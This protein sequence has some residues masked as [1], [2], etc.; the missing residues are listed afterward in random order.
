MENSIRLNVFVFDTTGLKQDY[1]IQTTQEHIDNT[2][3]GAKLCAKTIQMWKFDATT[4][5]VVYLPLETEN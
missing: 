1:S 4:Y 3:R 2:A 5:N